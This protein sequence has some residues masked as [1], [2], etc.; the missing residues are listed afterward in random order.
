M[1]ADAE[2][3]ATPLASAK[4][5]GHAEIEVYLR[6][7]RERVTSTAMQGVRSGRA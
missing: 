2:P 6:R 3:W 7:R 1:E 4:K 5:K